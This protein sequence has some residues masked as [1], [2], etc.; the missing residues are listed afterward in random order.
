[1]EE[2]LP[3]GFWIHLLSHTSSSIRNGV[4]LHLTF[5]AQFLPRSFF[6]FRTAFDYLVQTLKNFV[7]FLHT[8]YITCASTELVYQVMICSFR[9]KPHKFP[10]TCA[11]T[12]CGES[13]AVKILSSSMG[14]LRS[15]RHRLK[16]FW[17]LTKNLTATF[18]F[19][20]F[21]FSIRVDIQYD[22]IFS[23][24]QRSC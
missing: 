4:C 7:S 17:G 12:E 16:C 10:R 23:G 2:I 5:S 3:S 6:V 20:R 24:V 21:H 13:N 22:F 9:W 15:P 11:E 14:H 1:M 18:F 8:S 19:K